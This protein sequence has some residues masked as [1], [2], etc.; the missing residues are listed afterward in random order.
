MPR[1]VNEP[2]SGLGMDYVAKILMDDKGD[3]FY[4]LLYT[5]TPIW[6][7]PM[8]DL[9]SL[10]LSQIL[11]TNYDRAADSKQTM[12][13]GLGIDYVAKILMANKG[14]TF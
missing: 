12:Y 10:I 3:R 11:I 13:S 14:D 1:K 2:F 4:T 9:I 5:H 8:L 7:W 6:S